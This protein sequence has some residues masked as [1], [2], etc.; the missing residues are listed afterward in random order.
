MKR[1]FVA[2]FAAAALTVSAHAQNEIEITPAQSNVVYGMVSGAAM[3]M[4][5]YAPEDSNGLGVVVVPGSGW[6]RPEIYSAPQLKDMVGYDYMRAVVQALNAEG[7][8]AFVINHRS[9]PGNRFPAAVNDTRRAVRFVRATAEQWGI[10]PRHIATLG[11]SSGANLATMAALMDDAPGDGADPID[12]TSSAVQAVVGIATPFMLAGDPDTASAYAAQTIAM[13]TGVPFFGMDNHYQAAPPIAVQASPA[14]YVDADDPP[15]Y[16]IDSPDD[17]IVPPDQG[18]Y[19]IT[20]LDEAGA[21][22]THVRTEGGEHA[23]DFDMAA[24]A[25]WLE[26]VLEE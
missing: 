5:V 24:M 19:M 18:D 3:L 7:F 23:P 16:M 13:Y 22:Y 8:T 4:D 17:P 20:V 15:L 25:A 12:Q 11:H 21:T 2:A 6:Y 14:S 1:L 26:G 9:S 10:D